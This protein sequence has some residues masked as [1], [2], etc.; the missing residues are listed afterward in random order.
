MFPLQYLLLLL[1]LL[2]MLCLHG[3]ERRPMKIDDK[4]PAYW[5]WEALTDAVSSR[6]SS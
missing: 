2:S 1:L 5:G 6:A 4:Q 3:K